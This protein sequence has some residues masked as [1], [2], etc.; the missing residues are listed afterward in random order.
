MA[1]GNLFQGMARGKVGDVVFSRLNGQQISRVRNRQPANPQTNAQLYQRAI[2][3]TVMQA[4][5]AG[6]KIFDHS[7]EGKKTGSECQNAFLSLNALKLRSAISADL[8][9]N[10]ALADQVGHVIS[11]KQ[12]TVAPFSYIISDGNYDNDL[13]DELGVMPAPAAGQTIAQYCAA[14]GIVPGDYYTLVAFAVTDEE[15][16]KVNGSTGEYGTLYGSQFGFIRLKVKDTVTTDDEELTANSTKNKIFTVD[17]MAGFNSITGLGGVKLTDALTIGF[18]LDGIAASGVIRSRFDSG[19]RSRTE[20]VVKEDIAAG[21][22]SQYAL[23][24][25]KQGTAQVGN[26]DLILEGG[27]SF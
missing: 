19:V 23:D 9:N 13:T 24:A 22:I 10:R 21:I 15:L 5:S 12:K 3:A 4:Y 6:K 27:E 16:F 26:S 18:E 20:M 8:D 14:N 11:P 2:M 1:K 17:L 25:W 7:F